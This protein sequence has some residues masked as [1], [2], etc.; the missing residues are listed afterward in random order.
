PAYTSDPDAGEIS[1][2]DFYTTTTDWLSLSSEEHRRIYTW[3]D[4]HLFPTKSADWRA[5]GTALYYCNTILEGLNKIERT[6]DNAKTY[7][8]LKGQ[9]L[10]FRG[11][12]LLQNCFIWTLPYDEQTASTDLGLPLRLST[13]FNETSIRASLKVTYQQLLTDLRAAAH[14]LPVKPVS[15]IRACKVAAFA[16]LSRAY[17][18]MGNYPDALL[19]ADSCLQINSTLINYNDLAKSTATYPFQQL[20]KEVI[21]Q[22]LMAGGQIL[23]LTRARIVDELYN[24]YTEFD[25]RKS[26]FFTTN[27]DGTHG[28]KGRYSGSA[29]TFSGL[30][31]DEV[32][33][34]RAECYARAGKINEALND[35]NTLMITRWVTGKFVPFTANTKDAALSLILTERRKQLLFR[36]LRW[37]DLRRLNK[38]GAKITLNRTINGKEY[39]L[40]PNDLRYALPIPEDIIELSGMLQNPR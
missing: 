29:S 38:E 22:G 5:Y 20:N 23:N 19:Y 30:A 36:G 40:Y 18:S 7:D 15:Y 25:L 27:T 26:L 13:D 33:L 37:M 21:S 6:G 2:D 10:F 1:A 35:L 32:Y 34:N 12:S 11:K 14:L 8:D 24:S 9:A 31:I 28:F 16:C 4:D 17:L 39:I 3:Q